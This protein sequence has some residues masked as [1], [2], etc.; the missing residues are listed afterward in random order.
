[1]CVCNET[2][3]S[4]QRNHL[5]FSSCVRELLVIHW[6]VIVPF[7]PPL[8]PLFLPFIPNPISNYSSVLCVSSLYP[9]CK[10]KEITYTDTSNYYNKYELG[11]RK[12]KD[13]ILSCCHWN[14]LSQRSGNNLEVI[15]VFE[16]SWGVVCS[17]EQSCHSIILGEASVP[18]HDAG[19]DV[20]YGEGRRLLVRGRGFQ[21]GLLPGG[22]GRNRSG[23]EVGRQWGLQR[24]RGGHVCPI[25][26]GQVRGQLGELGGLRHLL[27][28]HPGRLRPWLS[29]QFF[30]RWSNL[31]GL[32]QL[33]ICNLN[34]IQGR[35]QRKDLVRMRKGSLTGQ[36][37]LLD[38]RVSVEKLDPL[39]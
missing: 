33:M 18:L 30:R 25:H 22:W 20:G 10:F 27:L 23:D 37:G 17:N 15:V 21:I 16:Y 4:V 29:A 3:S 5:I 13:E 24:V 32:P 31:G 34:A 9:S 28:A 7:H 36:T 1:M 2:K 19:L 11:W 6:K 38:Q 39:L 8:T 14:V 26:L 35:R 12:T